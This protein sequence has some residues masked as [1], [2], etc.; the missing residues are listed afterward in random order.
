MQTNISMG[1]IRVEPQQVRVE[2][3]SLLLVFEVMPKS[4][5]GKLGR[6]RFRIY[7]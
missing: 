5:G 3:C 2:L 7:N 1:I 6:D 4:S